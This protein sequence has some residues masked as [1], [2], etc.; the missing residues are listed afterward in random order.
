MKFLNHE[1]N[2]TSIID[3]TTKKLFN[4]KGFYLFKL[5]LRWKDIIESDYVEYCSPVSLKNV[6]QDKKILE[7]EIYN[8]G[9]VFDL[10][11]GKE[12]IIANINDF[13][14]QEIVTDIKFKLIEQTSTEFTMAD[15]ELVQ[16]N[17]PIDTELA[18]LIAEIDDDN[19]RKNLS[20]IARLKT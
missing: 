3:H 18:N 2:L 9:I 1:K 20:R 10:Q 8:S 14:H 4:S 15:K 16:D 6:S 7:I 17:K 5:I 11:Y 12:T 19:I 13:F